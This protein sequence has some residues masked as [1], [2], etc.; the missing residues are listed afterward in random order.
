MGE[1]RSAYKVL[2]GKRVGKRPLGKPR[3]RFKDNIKT[4]LKN[5]DARVQIG[6]IWLR[7]GTNG[8]LL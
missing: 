7:T 2:V 1:T 4:H 8:G 5:I 6:F 3:R